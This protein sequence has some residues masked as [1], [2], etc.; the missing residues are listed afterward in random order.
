MIDGTAMFFDSE[1][2]WGLITAGALPDGEPAWVHFS[3]IEMDGYR[4]LSIGQPV[5]FEYEKAEQDGYHYRA[6]RVL[7]A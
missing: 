1:Q 5:R 4:E 7:P 6:T 3:V 2:G